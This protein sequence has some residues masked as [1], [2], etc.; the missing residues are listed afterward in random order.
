MWQIARR[1]A[2]DAHLIAWVLRGSRL[3]GLEH[4][5]SDWDLL[6]IVRDGKSPQQRIVGSE[7]VLVEPI[8]ALSEALWE[9]RPME[10]DVICSRTLRFADEAW[11]PTL[12]AWCPNRLAYADQCESLALNRL[13][14]SPD[15]KGLRLAARCAILSQRMLSRRF[16]VQFDDADIAGIT[17]MSTLVANMLAA[18]R[19]AHEIYA[20]MARYAREVGA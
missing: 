17:H 6:A 11:M 15:D 13:R 12:Y 19:D 3:Y 5:G 7:D 4:A 16:S 8:S 14:R 20:Q 1:A 18:R 2:G 9:S 10:T